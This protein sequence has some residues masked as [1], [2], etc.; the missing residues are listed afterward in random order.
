MTTFQPDDRAQPTTVYLSADY[1]TDDAHAILSRHFGR[2]VADQFATRFWLD[3]IVSL[4][5]VGE[6]RQA[7]STI[8]TWV[9]ALNRS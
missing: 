9:R 4:G 2:E 3:F 8:E 1:T 6:T 7:F 5:G